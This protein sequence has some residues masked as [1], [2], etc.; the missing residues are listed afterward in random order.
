MSVEVV[1]QFLKQAFEDETILEEIAKAIEAG[2]DREGVVQ[3]AAKHGYQ[4]TP[5][6]LG[7]S[8]EEMSAAEAKIRQQA[9][10]LDDSDLD[11]VAGGNEALPTIPL[12]TPELTGGEAAANALSNVAIGMAPTGGYVDAVSKSPALQAIGNALAWKSP[13]SGPNW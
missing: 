13:T 3:V 2:G 9:T 4:F 12:R 11:A 6:E 7:S 5:E 8:I 1:S 10:E